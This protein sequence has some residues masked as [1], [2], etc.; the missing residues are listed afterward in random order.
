M[1]LSTLPSCRLFSALVQEN[2]RRLPVSTLDKKPV[3]TGLRDID[4][5]KRVSRQ[6]G[7]LKTA[8][9]DGAISPFRT[10][11]PLLTTRQ[12]FPAAEPVYQKMVYLSSRI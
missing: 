3:R 9:E 5:T 1:S 12:Q 10:Q 2:H 11:R 6:Y 8:I 4:Q 7:V